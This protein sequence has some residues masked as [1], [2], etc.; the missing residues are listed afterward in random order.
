MKNLKTLITTVLLLLSI[1]KSYSQWIVKS[2]DNKLDTPYK[3]AY[4]LSS[5]KKGMLKL[6]RVGEELYFYLTGAYFCDESLQ[7]D[8]AL[9]VNGESKRYTFT[10]TKSADNNT[11]FILDDINSLFNDE[12]LTDFKKASSAIV[13][14]NETYCTTEIYKFVMSGSTKAFT[15]K[16]QKYGF[17]SNT[18][19]KKI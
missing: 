10:C 2:V 8:I 14:V 15:T 16:M 7:T 9:I 5:D 3:I 17:I 19:S 6:E 12:F 13:R 1:N 18:P 4:C 11:V